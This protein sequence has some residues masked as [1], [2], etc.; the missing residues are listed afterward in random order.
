MK[1]FIEDK[2]DI[3]E[4][5]TYIRLR[6]Y[7]LKAWEELPESFLTELLAS[8]TAWHLAVI[9]ANGMHTKYQHLV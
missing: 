6:R 3:D 2:Y 8:M 4:K 1:D 7:V 9:D 5:P